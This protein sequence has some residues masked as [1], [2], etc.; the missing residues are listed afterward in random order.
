MSQLSFPAAHLPRGWFIVGW[1]H[2]LKA[3]EVKPLEYF[4]EHLV[5][6]RG[7][8]GAV[9]LQDAFCLH[10]GAHRGVKG[11]V[12]G[13]DLNCPWHGWVW[14]G[15]GSNTSIPYSKEGC[16]PRL[17]IRTYPVREWCGAIIAWFD[18]DRNGSPTWEMPETPEYEDPNY[19]RMHPVSS[20]VFRVKAHPQMPVENACDPAHIPLVHGASTIPVLSDV[21]TDGPVFRS[22]V[23]LTYG[24]GK[25]STALTPGGPVDATFQSNVY[26][27]GVSVVYWRSPDLVPSWMITGF[28]P[29]G[30]GYIDYYFSFASEREPGDTSEEPTGRALAMLKTQFDVIPQD[31]FTWENM[32]YLEKPNFAAEEAKNYALF[33]RWAMQFYPADDQAALEKFTG[34][35]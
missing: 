2:E 14:D 20:R 30:D 34:E 32:T 31:F 11:W 23:H 25:K 24:G 22:T 16:K 29:I 10:L 19:Y 8:S 4:G 26:G 28:T 15:N 35:D 5:L 21:G 12:T 6:W 9:F 33:R 13:D 1:G 27:I 7:E 18:W 3:G 17:R